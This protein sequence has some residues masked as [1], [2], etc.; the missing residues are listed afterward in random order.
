MNNIL[1]YSKSFDLNH[2][3]F[4]ESY[5]TK[6]KKI[7]HVVDANPCLQV[8]TYFEKSTKPIN[9]WGIIPNK[10][11]EIMDIIKIDGLDLDGLTRHKTAA[12]VGNYLM[13]EYKWKIGDIIILKAVANQKE[14]Q[15]VIKGVVYG[16]SNVSYI[17]Y[18]NLQYLQ[19]VMDNQGRV[20]FIYIK[21]DDPSSIAEISQSAEKL[22][23]NYP[24][25]VTTITQKSFMDSIVDKIKAILIAFRIIGWMTIISTFLLVANCIAIS[26]R[27][28]TMEIGVLRVLGFSRNKILFLVL[29]EPML[30]AIGGGWV[31]TL[32]GY[33][34]PAIHHITMPTEPPL[35]VSPDWHLVVYGLFISIL[36]GFLG[37]IFPALNSVHM[38]PSEAIRNVG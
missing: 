13:E 8:V 6:I 29:A 21:A 23:R 30:V 28:R 2:Y 16:Q 34:L 35:H 24:V 10:L 18:T 7:P 4:P 19:D 31:G 22:F 17:V 14:L 37:G 32:I 1:A 25:E 33:L 20:S 15:F 12:L 27:E 26:V 3:D 11:N 36:I 5:S 38:K 9:V